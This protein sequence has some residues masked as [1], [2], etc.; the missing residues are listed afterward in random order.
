MKIILNVLVRF[1]L[2]VASHDTEQGFQIDKDK[3]RGTYDMYDMRNLF[4]SSGVARL[5]S[6][7]FQHTRFLPSM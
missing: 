4:R 5:T 7:Q 3:E 6:L 2:A 1:Q